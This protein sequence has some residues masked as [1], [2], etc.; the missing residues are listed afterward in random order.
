MMTI[1]RTPTHFT[2]LPSTAREDRTDREN[3]RRSLS[4]V[5][6]WP[7]MCW[8]LSINIVSAPR[9]LSQRA[10]RSIVWGTTLVE[11]STRPPAIAAIVALQPYTCT[12]ACS[13][14]ADFSQPYSSCALVPRHNARRCTVTFCPL[15]LYAPVLQA[16]GSSTRVAF[17]STP[18]GGDRQGGGS[19]RAGSGGVNASGSA[20]IFNLFV[21]RAGDPTFAEI[22]VQGGWSVARVLEVIKLKLNLEGRASAM[23]VRLQKAGVLGTPLDSTLTVEEAKLS[24]KDRLIVEVPN[25]TVVSSA[26]SA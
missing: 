3:S 25:V 18:S 7:E 11:R 4:H 19:E 22:D 23:E 16:F 21:K 12:A 13:V 15:Q 6:A 26:S 20:M 24:N 5:L 14:C 9:M 8:V 2:P 10:A 17:T 1:T